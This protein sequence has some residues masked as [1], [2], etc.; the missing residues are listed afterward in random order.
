MLAVAAPSER[1][2]EDQ[3]VSN[4]KILVDSGTIDH[5]SSCQSKV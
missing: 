3:E 4:W 5:L 1:E 2:E